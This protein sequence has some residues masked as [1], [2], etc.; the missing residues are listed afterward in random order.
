MRILRRVVIVGLLAS[1]AVGGVA[2]GDELAAKLKVR[3][4]EVLAGKR[5]LAEVRLDVALAQADRR[6]LTV[7]G[8]GVGVWNRAKQFQIKAAELKEMLGRLDKYRYFD[9]PENPKSVPEPSKAPHGPRI[10]RSV[11]I[12][13]GDLQRNVLQTDRVYALPALEALAGEMFTLCEKAAAKGMIA[14]SLRDGLLKVARGTLAGEV[15]SIAVNL[16]PL[17]PREGRPGA[18]G[19]VILLEGRELTWTAQAPGQPPAVPVRI[20]IAPKRIRALAELF[21]ERGFAK[22]PGNLY[23]DRYI[24][25]RIAVLDRAQ[26]VQARA[27]AGMD[28]ATHAAEQKALGEVI[29]AILALDPGGKGAAAGSTAAPTAVPAPR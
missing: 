2:L 5:P 10:M 14:G 6:V 16:P 17:A 4:D 9:M 3:V 21:A 18:P 7:F 25:V 11:G 28:P 27:F 12:R 1:L 24:D 23:R 13:V 19:V 22:L 26:S 20:D 15:L 8:S 29:D